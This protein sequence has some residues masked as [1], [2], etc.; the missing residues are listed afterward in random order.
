MLSILD[1]HTG[2]GTGMALVSI[3]IYP[4]VGAVLGF[5][6]AAIVFV[7]WKLMGSRESVPDGVPVYGIPCRPVAD[8]NGHQCCPVH[9]Y[10][11][12]YRHL[13]VFLCNREHRDAQDLLAARMACV[14]NYWCDT[15]CFAYQ[16]AY[17]TVRGE[18]MRYRKQLEQSTQEMQENSAEARK[19][20]EEM[21]KQLEKK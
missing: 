18:T 20:L 8:N 10:A 14:R 15:Y 17:R 1:I 5:V 6:G 9:R 2:V 7:I 21:Q 12:R 13:G 19:A 11:D 4:L 16:R 3:I